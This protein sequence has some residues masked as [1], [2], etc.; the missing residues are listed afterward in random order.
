L[1]RVNKYLQSS[2]WETRTAAGY[3]I[4]AISENIAVWDPPTET[5]VAEEAIVVPEKLSFASFSVGSVLSNG[6]TL[7][8]SGGQ[9]FDFDELEKMPL[10]ARLAFQQKQINE[11]LGFFVTVAGSLVDNSDLMSR[12]RVKK[13]ETAAPVASDSD[14]ELQK[15]I[16]D[17]EALI[18]DPSQNAR[19]K[20]VAKRKLKELKKKKE[21]SSAPMN[22]LRTTKN[23]PTKQVVTAQPQQANKIVVESV[24]NSDAALEDLSNGPHWPFH[25]FLSN[26]LNNLF[27]PNWTVRH[28]AAIGLR[29]VLKRHAVAAGKVN[30]L[31][32]SKELKLMGECN[33][34]D[35]QKLRNYQWLEDAAIRLLCVLAL[36]RFGDYG[37]DN[38]IAPVRETVAQVLGIIVKHVNREQLSA[39]IEALSQLQRA[40]DW[41]VRHSGFLGTKYLISVWSTDDAV[42]SHILNTQLPAILIGLKDP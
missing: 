42:V 28:G 18:A 23:T 11:K 29:G 21:T 15:Q 7:M 31:A 32:S 19:Q 17:L 37:S 4:E 33:I 40:P 12:T 20:N 35:V 39:I 1:D 6:T 38:T 5:M 25:L 16:K 36:D 8:S 34:T 22:F 14:T 9:E 2:T 27:D 10:E 13:V 24:V 30:A 26:L 3:A 41:E